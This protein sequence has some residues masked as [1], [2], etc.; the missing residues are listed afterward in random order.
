MRIGNRALAC[1]AKRAGRPDADAVADCCALLLGSGAAALRS[2]G[3]K[4][5][6]KPPF[7]SIWPRSRSSETEGGAPGE[8]AASQAGPRRPATLAGPAHRQHVEGLQ[9]PAVRGAAP[10]AVGQSGRHLAL[11][12][13][14]CA[15]GARPCPGGCPPYR[16]PTLNI[17]ARGSANSAH[18]DFSALDLVPDKPLTRRQ[19]FNQICRVHALKGPAS[20]PARLLRLCPFH[21]DTRSFRRWGSAGRGTNHPALSWSAARILRHRPPPESRN[22]TPRLAP[23]FHS[24][25]R[26]KQQ[27]RR[28]DKSAR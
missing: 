11:R 26:R 6:A 28:D 3:T 5:R 23:K 16:N 15:A 21:I 4:D 17:C 20:A 8:V 19:I 14:P 7:A 27:L 22:P 2:C 1:A 9:R 10:Q 25:S 18:R 13:R 12:A 24:N